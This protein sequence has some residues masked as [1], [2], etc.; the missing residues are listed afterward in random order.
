MQLAASIM[1]S[2]MA[3]PVHYVTRLTLYQLFECFCF[4]GR[5]A[6]G[7]IAEKWLRLRFGIEIVAWV[8]YGLVGGC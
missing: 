6:A 7:A 2:D 5:V 3:G 1:V 8:R 4:V